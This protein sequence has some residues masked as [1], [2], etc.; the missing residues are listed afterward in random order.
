MRATGPTGP[1][2]SPLVQS[3]KLSG[4]VLRNGT[5][6][7]TIAFLKSNRPDGLRVDERNG[8]ICRCYLSRRVPRFRRDRCR[9]RSDPL[10]AGTAVPG[11]VIGERAEQADGPARRAAAPGEHGYEQ[12]HE[13]DRPDDGD[14]H[15]R[16][17]RR[18]QTDCTSEEMLAYRTTRKR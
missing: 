16:D 7:G 5:G 3:P 14:E 17:D 8:D 6:G 4:P 15:D 10:A 12:E 18:G 9:R 1:T 2:G 13:R 11:A